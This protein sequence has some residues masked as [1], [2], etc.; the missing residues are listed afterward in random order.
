MSAIELKSGNRTETV[1]ILEKEGNKITILLGRKEYHLDLVKVEKNIFSI[2][3]DGKSY[4]IEVVATEKKNRYNVRYICNS[5]NVEILDAEMRYMQNRQKTGSG[6]EEN[7]ISSPM[8]GKIVRVMVKTG[9]KVTEG[10]VV[11]IVS[12]MKM[13][14]EYKSGK[15]GQVKEVL[16][17]EGDVIDANMPLIV[18][19]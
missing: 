17:T 5:Y 2:L 10:Q 15:T 14:S 8:P 4:D 11:I 9:D 6:S 13:E 19:E 3:H 16:V 1:E 7:I 12:A 18:L